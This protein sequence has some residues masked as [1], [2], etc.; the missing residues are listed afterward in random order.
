[1]MWNGLQKFD[2]SNVTTC[3]A[4]NSTLTVDNGG[5]QQITED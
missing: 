5:G 3:R 1:M 2:W 4:M